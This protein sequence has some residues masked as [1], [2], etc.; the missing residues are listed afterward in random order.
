MSKY[1]K[2]FLVVI[3]IS[4]IVPQIALA[5]WWNPFSWNIFNIFSKPQTIIQNQTPQN[6]ASQKSNP[7]DTKNTQPVQNATAPNTTTQNNTTK[8]NPPPVASVSKLTNAQI[9]KKVKPAVVYIET[10]DGSGSGMIIS[11]DGYILT[12]AHVVEGFNNAQVTTSDGTVYAGTVIGRDENVD[13]AVIKIIANNLTKVIFGDSG[14]L[15]QGDAVFTLGFPFGIKGDVSFK[16][17]TVSREVQDSQNNTY[18][19]TSAEIHPGNSGGPLV[20]IYGQVVGINTAAYGEA[21]QG[22]QVGETIKLAIPIDRAIPLIPQLKAGSNV[23]NQVQQADKQKICADIKTESDTMLTNFKGLA[24]SY[25]AT[26]KEI[27]DAMVMP[28]TSNPIDGF[29]QV[30]QKFLAIHD[31]VANKTQLIQDSY[32]K[33]IFKIQY[34]NPDDLLGA[35]NAMTKAAIYLKGYYDQSLD[36]FDWIVTNRYWNDYLKAKTGDM[37]ASDHTVLKQ[38]NDSFSNFLDYWKKLAGEY[39]DANL[40]NKCGLDIKL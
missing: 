35:S 29:K 24:D 38:S 6:G 32:K 28:Q 36:T 31:D 40:K 30:E 13:V 22:V 3:F 5:A 12:N 39:N 19:E 9:I 17:G 1:L 25:V 33:T 4:F 14:K 10:D 26:N 8:N 20:N 2:S 34:G 11:T 7:A 23:I 21:V 27:T 37:L 18:I 15:Q 16:D